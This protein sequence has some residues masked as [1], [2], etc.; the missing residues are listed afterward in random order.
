MGRVCHAGWAVV[1]RSSEVVAVM[2]TRR[3][4]VRRL[5]RERESGR[6]VRLVE[7]VYSTGLME[8]A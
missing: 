5:R 1:T 6:D 2:L 7:L 8:D 3:S 4:A